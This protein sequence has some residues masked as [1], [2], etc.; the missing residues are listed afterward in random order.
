M[1]TPWNIISPAEKNTPPP[2]KDAMFCSITVFT[3]DTLA[4]CT[5]RAA[6]GE[7]AG[8]ETVENARRQANSPPPEV[9]PLLKKVTFS[10]LTL[11]PSV[12]QGME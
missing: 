3:S 6:T 5:L 11:E 1:L 12:G 7:E 4:F 10:N 9:A 8:Y 2:S